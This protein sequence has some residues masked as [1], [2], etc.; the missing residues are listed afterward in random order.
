MKKWIVTV[1]LTLL[2]VI[3][4]SFFW[5]NQLVYSLP[6]PVPSDYKTVRTGQKIKLA[7][8]LNFNNNKPVFL[9]FFNPDCPCSRFNIDHFKSLV[10]TYHNR[11]NF[12]VVLMTDK[13]NSA[14]EV[15]KRFGISVPVIADST[16]AALCGVYSTPQAVVLNANRELYYRGNYNKS[17]YCTDAKTSYALIAL[18][19]VLNKKHILNEDI[20][21][22]KS[23]GC[24]LPNCKN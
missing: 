21:A 11:V 17:R 10:K 9:H 5:Y 2:M 3:I 16:V 13:S 23:Y 14:E 22:L 4:F 12:A 20:F 19:G 8:P 15:K 18:D 7:S 1:W 24:K 6:T